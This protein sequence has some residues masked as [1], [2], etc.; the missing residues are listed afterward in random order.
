MI[1]ID[2]ISVIIFAMLSILLIHVRSIILFTFAYWVTN[3]IMLIIFNALWHSNAIWRNRTGSTLVWVMAC[4]LTAPSHYRN[5]CWLPI[6]E[7]D[8]YLYE[9]NFSANSAAAIQFNEFEN[10]TFKISATSFK[11]QWMSWLCCVVSGWQHMANQSYVYVYIYIY[12]FNI[13]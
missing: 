9:S 12:G 3:A 2:N 13:S 6:S 10:D 1:D 5:Q 4:C 8:W 7:V 11:G